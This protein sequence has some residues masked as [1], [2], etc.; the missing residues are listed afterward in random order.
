VA[1]FEQVSV[2]LAFLLV[3]IVVGYV[4]FLI[5]R[6]S[7]HQQKFEWSG[8]LAV[9]TSLAGGGFLSYWADHRNFAA[10]GIGYFIGFVTY[11]RLLQPASLASDPG[12]S[13]YVAGS[14]AAYEDA[15]PSRGY[16][17]SLGSQAAGAQPLIPDD[18]RP[19]ETPSELL[20]A[21]GDVSS[22][23]EKRIIAL[24]AL[25]TGMHSASI[26]PTDLLLD[27]GLSTYDLCI[28]T[29]VLRSGIPMSQQPIDLATVNDLISFVGSSS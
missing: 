7:V 18:P 21:V 27:L 10:Y 19:L 3:G 25:R 28:L 5:F 20:R 15:T 29:V 13:R 22:S 9:I 11:W 16:P 23:S 26:K 14:A 2:L 4:T 6:I 17:L 8:A 12:S 1:H 24:P